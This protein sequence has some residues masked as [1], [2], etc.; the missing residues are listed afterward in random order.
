MLFDLENRVF[1]KKKRFLFYCSALYSSIHGFLKIYIV[2][3]LLLTEVFSIV[4]GL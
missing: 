1:V 3:I 4:K 2:I